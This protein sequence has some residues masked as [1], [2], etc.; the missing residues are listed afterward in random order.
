M[1]F[2]WPSNHKGQRDTRRI[3]LQGNLKL[4]LHALKLVASK[5]ETGHACITW[6]MAVRLAILRVHGKI[7][8]LRICCNACCNKRMLQSRF[9]VPMKVYPKRKQ[10]RPR[11]MFAY[12]ITFYW[13]GGRAENHN[14]ERFYTYSEKFTDN[15][16]QGFPFVWRLC[17]TTSFEIT[18]LHFP[19]SQDPGKNGTNCK[20]QYPTTPNTSIRHLL[21]LSEK[22]L[23]PK[24]VYGHTSGQNKRTQ[25]T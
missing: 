1:A 17:F 20:R 5:I 6:L 11:N 12:E 9:F 25:Q 22:A 7:M 4:T 14:R 13:T 2:C 3:F 8:W 21:H 19:L 16:G 18:P 15:S 23:S 10:L 24:Q